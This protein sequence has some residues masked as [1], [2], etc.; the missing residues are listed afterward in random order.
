MT[1][2][3][4]FSTDRPYDNTPEFRKKACGGPPAD[5]ISPGTPAPD[6]VV[7]R[8][9]V[10]K[11]AVVLEGLNLPDVSQATENNFVG[12]FERNVPSCTHAKT[13]EESH[14]EGRK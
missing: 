10:N 2:E 9:S 11:I 8:I 14:A 13:R 3:I 1:V 4:E 7:T 12:A 6:A 5:H